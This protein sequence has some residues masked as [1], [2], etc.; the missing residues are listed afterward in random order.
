MGQISET[1]ASPGLRL[2]LLLE[3][4]KGAT[5]DFKMVEGS[6]LGIPD[7]YGGD[8]SFCLC[9]IHLPGRV[10]PITA[11]KPVA[12]QGSPDE[13][14]ILCTKTLGR[15]LK[16]AGYPDDLKD[17]KAL[18]LWRQRSAEINAIETGRVAQLALPSAAQQEANPQGDEM[19]RALNAAAV[20]T[21]DA[22]GPD[23]R[24]GSVSEDM[25]MLSELVAGLDDV[26]REAFEVFCEQVGA[27]LG[28]NITERQLDQLLG[29]FDAEVP[30][31]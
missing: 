22:V 12:A 16:R 25:S 26:D 30:E 15:A 20:T 19:Q 2:G 13:W 31:A 8:R 9:T 28:G 10:E 29:W 5:Y 17:L 27:K 14:N 6:E 4:H 23:E 7:A 3:D 21:P 18:V 11:W 24:S 1:Y